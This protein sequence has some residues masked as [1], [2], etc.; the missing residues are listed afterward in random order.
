LELFGTQ[1]VVW[2]LHLKQQNSSAD[3][4]CSGTLQDSCVSSSRGLMPDAHD[5]S[6]APCGHGS[7]GPF[8]E[9]PEGV[10]IVALVLETSRPTLVC[11]V[12]AA[13]VV[14]TDIA[15]PEVDPAEVIEALAVGLVE[16]PLATCPPHA[17]PPR[18]A[19]ATSHE[20]R[21]RR[22]RRWVR[23]TGAIDPAR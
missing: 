4:M 16:E 5:Q 2:K 19:T 1:A 22:H 13:E 11:E 12:V 17:P 10:G 18:A 8:W 9:Q 6:W 7:T 23:A 3:G 15:A 21:A 14:T 20:R